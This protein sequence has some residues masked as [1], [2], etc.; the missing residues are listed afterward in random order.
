MILRVA[1]GRHVEDQSTL[2]LLAGTLL[3]E[4]QSELRL[5]DASGTEHDCQGP[6]QQTATQHCVQFR[7]TGLFA[8]DRHRSDQTSL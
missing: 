2:P 7:H 4:V 1:A 8:V 6:G 5:P 3:S